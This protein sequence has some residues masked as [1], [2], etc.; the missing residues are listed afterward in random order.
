MMP[1]QHRIFLAYME[2]MNRKPGVATSRDNCQRQLYRFEIHCQSHGIDPAQV[3]LEQLDDYVAWIRNER[4]LSDG[5]V[6]QALIQVKAAYRYA[7]KRG[8]IPADPCIDLFLP[9]LVET[10][11]QT[12]SNAEL[13]EILRSCKSE[14]DRILFHVLAYTGM[15]RGEIRNLRWDEINFAQ[16][17]VTVMHAK[18]RKIRKVPIHPV[19]QDVLSH[20]QTTRTYVLGNSHRD[21]PLSESGFDVCF[22]PVMETAQVSG[23]ARVFRKTVATSLYE[24]GV[25][26]LTIDRMLGWAPRTVRARHYT[27]IADAEMQRAIYALYASDPIS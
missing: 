27:R 20:S 21:G 14:R 22:Y 17:T 19:L 18:G 13:R 16:S 15:R 1:L 9:P 25:R 3:T 24:A 23:T 8:A 6:R 11:P 2:R 7:H 10:E 12:F 5:S 4:K 26:D